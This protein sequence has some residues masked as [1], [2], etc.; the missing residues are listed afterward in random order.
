MIQVLNL[1]KIQWDFIEKQQN[2]VLVIKTEGKIHIIFNLED[3]KLL[4]MTRNE[5]Q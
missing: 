3:D 2:M 1:K 5:P 4:Q